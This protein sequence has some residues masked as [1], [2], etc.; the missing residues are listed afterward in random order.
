MFPFLIHEQIKWHQGATS[1]ICYDLLRSHI[2]N[3]AKLVRGE[4]PLVAW[5]DGD[6]YPNN[7][8]NTLTDGCQCNQS[9][10]TAAIGRVSL[11]GSTA[12]FSFTFTESSQDNKLNYQFEIKPFK[13]PCYY[14]A[15]CIIA[16]RIAYFPGRWNAWYLLARQVSLNKS[17]SSSVFR[18]MPKEVV[19]TVKFLCL[20]YAGTRVTIKL[21]LQSSHLLYCLII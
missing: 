3:P 9:T 18:E 17:V 10:E 5:L 13:L 19:E 2:D 7:G 11:D 4:P 16:D 1:R 6:W 14:I 21:T 20:G 8:L 15:D 12:V